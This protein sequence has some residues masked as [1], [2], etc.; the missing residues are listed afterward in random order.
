[1]AA[2]LYTADFIPGN[3]VTDALADPKVAM[4]ADPGFAV[5]CIRTDAGLGCVLDTA[6]DLAA[7]KA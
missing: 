2:G 6:L 4:R 1:M 5:I 3:N 7:S